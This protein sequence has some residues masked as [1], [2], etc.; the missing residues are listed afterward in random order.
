MNRGN[1]DI[2]DDLALH[3]IYG[4]IRDIH[5]GTHNIFL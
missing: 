3:I 1:Y 5:C 2:Y 4:G